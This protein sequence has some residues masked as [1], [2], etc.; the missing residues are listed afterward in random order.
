M[1]KIKVELLADDREYTLGTEEDAWTHGL[2]QALE[3]GVN[4]DAGTAQSTTVTLRIDT[5]SGER[6][7]AARNW[8]SQLTEEAK[9]YYRAQG[10]AI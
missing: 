5:V 9:A 6:H 7:P 1:R 10:Y 3:A 4:V 8:P 2:A